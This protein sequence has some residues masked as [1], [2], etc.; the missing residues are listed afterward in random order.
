MQILKCLQNCQELKFLLG[1]T[2][3]TW[4]RC[5]NPGHQEEEVHRAP[6]DWDA[7]EVPLDV[8]PGGRDLQDLPRATAEST[9]QWR[10]GHPAS[11]EFYIWSKISWSGRMN[12]SSWVT[13]YR[14]PFTTGPDIWWHW[15][16]PCSGSNKCDCHDLAKLQTSW[17]LL[18]I[19]T[20]LSKYNKTHRVI[21]EPEGWGVEWCGGD[22]TF[23]TNFYFL[24]KF[25]GQGHRKYYTFFTQWLMIDM[26]IEQSSIMWYFIQI[27]WIFIV[28]CWA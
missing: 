11:S 19:L 27:V 1:K 22:T 5:P 7:E 25:L 9:I 8:Q 10:H 13:I 28:E 6:A 4:S 15:A 20:E 16:G 3:Q 2:L 23:L 26:N 18:F 21:E 12:R 17:L 14:W 24:S